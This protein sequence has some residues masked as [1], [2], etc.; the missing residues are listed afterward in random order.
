MRRSQY[1]CDWL[2][3]K[4]LHMSFMR[5]IRS[6]SKACGFKE[7]LF[8]VWCPHLA[9]LGYRIYW[10]VPHPLKSVRL[11]AVAFERCPRTTR[12]HDLLVLMWLNNQ[13]LTLQSLWG[14]RVWP[15]LFF[16]WRPDGLILHRCRV[17]L[18]IPVKK[19]SRMD[20][21]ARLSRAVEPND[22]T[23]ESKMM[24]AGRRSAHRKFA[25][26]CRL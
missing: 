24:W 23:R 12:W 15:R 2:I 16:T 1:P 17:R 26:R 6:F 8:S 22:E 13:R 3:P 10:G 5:K 11:P 9:M 25:G 21:G 4:N 18:A 14:C 20:A 7:H 19:A